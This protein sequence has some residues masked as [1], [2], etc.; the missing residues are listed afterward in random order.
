[1]ERGGVAI[2]NY[3]VELAV[4][5]PLPGAVVVIPRVPRCDTTALRSGDFVEC[6]AELDGVDQQHARV[7]GWCASPHDPCMPGRQFTTNNHP[8]GF[9]AEHR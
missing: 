5:D 2:P 8:D 9:G 3:V 1:L 7:A 6:A 4:D